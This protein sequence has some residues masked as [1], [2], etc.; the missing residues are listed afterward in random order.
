MLNETR[1]GNKASSE[2]LKTTSR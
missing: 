1:S 2:I